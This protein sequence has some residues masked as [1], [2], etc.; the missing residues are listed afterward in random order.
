M[1]LMAN[2]GFCHEWFGGCLHAGKALATPIA[3]LQGGDGRHGAFTRKV[4]RGCV[5]LA[6]QVLASFSTKEICAPFRIGT[7]WMR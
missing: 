3:S 1:E 6:R 2:L 5:C 4:D 7:A